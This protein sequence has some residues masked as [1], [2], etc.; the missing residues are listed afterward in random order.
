[1]KY[2]HR[3]RRF[4]FEGMSSYVLRRAKFLA[5]LETILSC[6]ENDRLLLVNPATLE[7][8][9]SEHDREGWDSNEIY[10]LYIETGSSLELNWGA[11]SDLVDQYVFEHD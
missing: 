11:I 1:M 9:L 2:W 3:E 5:D 4:I 6:S 8:E 7:M 10:D